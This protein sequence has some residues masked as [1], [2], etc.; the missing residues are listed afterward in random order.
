MEKIINELE[1]LKND[2]MCEVSTDLTEKE[3]NELKI[4]YISKKGKLSLMNQHMKTVSDKKAFGQTLN[5]VKS[6]I[7]SVL[8]ESFEIIKIKKIEVKLKESQIDVTLSGKPN[9]KSKQNI[10]IKCAREVEKIFQNMGFEIAQGYEVESDFYNFEALNLSINHPARD[11]QDTFYIN[12][13]LLLR[14][15]TSN[16]QVRTMESNKNCSFKIITP[17]KVYRRDDDDATHSHQFMQIEGLVVVNKDTGIYASLRELKTV[18][19]LFVNTYFQR[20]DIEIRMRPSYFP[21]T[22]PSVEVDISCTSC[23]G[24]GCSFCKNTGWIEVLGAGIV[25]KKVLQNSGYDSEQFSAYA[26]GIGVERL[27]LLKYE[28]DDIRKIYVNDYRFLEQF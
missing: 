17:G 6:Y 24:K 28:I 10:L 23:S 15:H 14:T 25:H 8:E 27:A 18:L 19:S 2:F 11:M 3:L 20:D 13:E 7:E 16:S 5:E 22:E 1:Q 9:I 21:F 26:F 4:K 12:P